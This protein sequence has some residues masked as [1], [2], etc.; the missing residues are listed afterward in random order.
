MNTK[1]AITLISLFLLS[2][3]SCKKTILLPDLSENPKK[4]SQIFDIF[5]NKMNINYVYWDV[6]TTNWNYIYNKYKPIFAQLNIHNNNDV[7]KSVLYFREMTSGLIDSHYNLYFE[8]SSIADLNIYPALDRKLL[9]PNF[10]SP[11]LYTN[12]DSNYFDKGFV[13]GNY[14]SYSQQSVFSLSATIKNKILYF[15]CNHFAL[16]EAYNQDRNNGTQKT[17][18]FFFNQLQNTSLNIKGIII[19][20]RNNNGGNINDL[21]FLIGSLINKPLIF[22]YTHYKSGNNRLSYTPWVEAIIQPQLQKRT[23]NFP[24]IALADNYSVSLAEA[25]TMAISALPNGIFIG[26]NTWGATGPITDNTVYNDGPFNIPN[27]LSVFTSS[28]AFKYINNKR[29][30]GIGFPP[31]IYIPFNYNSLQNGRDLQLEKAISLIN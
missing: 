1:S 6:D 8:H 3:S 24:I 11:F 14:F 4:F 5:W 27:F 19:D 12:I 13:T 2:L 25:V 23:I 18:N 10:H 28:G 31:D 7:N 21:N 17:L 16:E 15:Y 20:V 30:E 22:G 29:Y 9:Q 26:E